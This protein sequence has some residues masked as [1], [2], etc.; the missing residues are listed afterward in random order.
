M[1][2]EMTDA[3][4]AINAAQINYWNETAGPVWVRMQAQLDHQ[5]AGIGLEAIRVLDPHSGEHVLDIGCGCGQT[6]AQLAERLSPGGAVTGVDISGP[7]LEV[8]R[9]RPLPADAQTRFLQADAQTA[10]LGTAVFDAAFSRFGVMFFSD[11]TAAFR[12]IARALKPG[13][14][15]GLRLLGARRPEQPLDDRAP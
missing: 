3:G 4:G 7:M 1:G 13:R 12:N 6:T 8:A 15:A 9:G 14:S 11:P 2:R 10:D 5:I